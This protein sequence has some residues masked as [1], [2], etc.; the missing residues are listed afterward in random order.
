MIVGMNKT[1]LSHVIVFDLHDVLFKRSYLRMA[2]R[3]LCLPNKLKLCA[4]LGNPRFII[5]ALLLLRT[6]SPGEGLLRIL[7]E[8]YNGL[9]PYVEQIID[10]TL[11]LTPN[12]LMLSL[13]K[14]LLEAGYPIYLFSNIGESGYKKL[15]TLYPWFSELFA[16]THISCPTNG[17]INKPRKKAY[18]SFIGSFQL[19]P[20]KIIFID[21]KKHNIKAAEHIG[22]TGITYRSPEQVKILLEQFLQ[23]Q[24]S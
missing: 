19:N 1:A 2:L 23:R 13:V 5:Q 12:I 22:M 7:A 9:Q 24:L 16:G 8:Q 4:I 21:D 6:Y 20:E 10:V 3:L 14:K 17:W 11:E 15:L 18:T